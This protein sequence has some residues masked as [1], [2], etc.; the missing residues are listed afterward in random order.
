MCVVW[1][2][3]TLE[4]PPDNNTSSVNDT[5]FENFG[6]NWSQYHSKLSSRIQELLRRQDFP[7]LKSANLDHLS[8][9]KKIRRKFTSS[10]F[11]PL[12]PKKL[13]NSTCEGK[14]QAFVEQFSAYSSLSPHAI[15]LIT[16]INYFLPQILAVTISS[17]A[18][19]KYRSTRVSSRASGMLPICKFSSKNDLFSLNY[20]QYPQLQT[21]QISNQS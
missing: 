12:I 10:S 4:N 15:L 18:Y 13:K 5:T 6:K 19:L 14:A 7:L 2:S 17:N 20:Q 3:R 21:S 16:A 9:V 1:S 11:S 8:L